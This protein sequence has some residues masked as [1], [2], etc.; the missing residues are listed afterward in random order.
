MEEE[1]FDVNQKITSSNVYDMLKNRK[2]IDFPAV[3][4]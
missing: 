2:N 1:R 3:R 4:A